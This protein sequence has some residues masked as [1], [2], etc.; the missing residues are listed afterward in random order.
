MPNSNISSLG[1][2]LDSAMAEAQAAHAAIAK[3]IAEVQAARDVVAHINII[4][5]D[6]HT[7]SAAV[8]WHF[9]LRALGVIGRNEAAASRD[10]AHPVAEDE[11]VIL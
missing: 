10:V 7:G 11:F 5:Q 9:V 2:G 4:N 1:L 6:K 3:A 8:V